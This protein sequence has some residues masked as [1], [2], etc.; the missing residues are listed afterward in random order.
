MPVV[1]SLLLAAATLSAGPNCTARLCNP[2]VLAPLSSKL[3]ATAKRQFR[4]VQIGDSLTAGD[5]LSDG[6]RQQLNSH[7]G[8][9]GRG[10]VAGGRPYAG[11]LT[12]GVT[13]HNSP[14]WAFNGTFGRLWHDGAPPIGLSSYT[15]TAN[16][17]GEVLSL[18]ADATDYAFDSFTICGVTGPAEGNVIVSFGGLEKEMSFTSP[19]PGALCRSFA[20]PNLA[21]SATVTTK[22]IAPVSITSMA[23]FRGRGGVSLSNLG[24][25]GSLLRNFQRTDDKVVAAELA[26]YRPDL[27][28]IAF[29]TNEGFDTDLNV[30]DYDRLLR[31]QVLRIRRLAGIGIPIML[32]GP[33]NA[34]T[35]SSE[36]ANAGDTPATVCET[37]LMVP[38]HIAAVRSVQRRVAAEMGL[39]FWDWGAAMDTPCAMFNWRTA[40]LATRD[41]VHL[42]RPGGQRL[43]AILAADFE[44]A[45]GLD[46]WVAPLTVPVK[47]TTASATNLPLPQD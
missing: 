31:A 43:G 1:S 4:I 8:N 34:M 9:G 22:N 5:M 14:G 23:S 18:T 44:A 42:T 13:T 30:A 29:G 15:K 46:S 2:A 37:G 36:I 19:T 38:G 20:A 10:A 41:A 3:K 27:I 6:W 16:S 47:P 7:F 25:P 26:A 24:V 32:L 28:G 39:A 40:K 12:W 45:L 17:P 35:R 11:F 33:P 21:L